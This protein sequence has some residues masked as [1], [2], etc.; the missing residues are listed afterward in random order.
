MWRRWRFG[1]EL[2]ILD[3]VI[4]TVAVDVEDFLASDQRTADLFHDDEP[5]F[6]LPACGV[7]VRVALTE[8][9]RDVPAPVRFPSSE[10]LRYAS[11]HTTSLDRLI[12]SVKR[13]NRR[14][15]LSVPG[16]GRAALRSVVER[17]FACRRNP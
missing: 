12:R 16:K 1:D 9:D 14:Q 8:P 13:R 4:E 5:V 2:E 15:R 6:V 11:G 7:R 10:L 3:P 17:L